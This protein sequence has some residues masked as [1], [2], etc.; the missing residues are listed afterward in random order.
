MTPTP[1]EAAA[2]VQAAAGAIT[3]VTAPRLPGPPAELPPV[4]FDRL[5]V[6]RRV[7]AFIT[8]AFTVPL[9]PRNT[10]AAL[11]YDLMRDPHT[12]HPPEPNGRLEVD[13]RTV[14]EIAQTVLEHLT[15]LIDA[16]LVELRDDESYAVTD[17]GRDELNS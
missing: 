5:S 16:G 15:A 7:L 10:L 14:E 2:Q 8:D 3:E 4:L 13:G 12:T 11:T 17:A 6:E 9:G 1:E